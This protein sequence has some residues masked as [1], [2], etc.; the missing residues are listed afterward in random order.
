MNNLV[1][2]GT[3]APRLW[4]PNTIS[5]KELGLLGVMACPVA[6]SGKCV[7]DLEHLTTTE[8]V[9]LAETSEISKESREPT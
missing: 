1:V 9:K 3:P 5:R 7:R 6:R 4:L 2:A 8:A